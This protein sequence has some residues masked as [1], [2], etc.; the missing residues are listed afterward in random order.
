MSKKILIVGIIITLLLSNAIGLGFYLDQEKENTQ[1]KS[2]VDGYRLEVKR[3]DNYNKDLVEII[4]NSNE[5]I[6]NLETNIK[7]KKHKILELE[8]KLNGLGLTKWRD[9]QRRAKTKP[10]SAQSKN[11]QR[12]EVTDE[13][14]D[15][16]CRLVEAESGTEPYN[17]RVAV[18]QVVL[19]RVADSRFPNNIKDVIYQP[20][21]F[22]VVRKGRLDITPKESTVEA[23]HEAL[24]G[25]NVIGNCI[26]FW[27]TYVDK[28]CSLWELPIKYTIGSHVFTDG[29]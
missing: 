23:V 15:L 17:G 12:K 10:S 18:A 2:T 7:E 3:L 28:S 16:L 11:R 20:Y 21:Q 27:A 19:N 5:Q 4:N 6:E 9:Q 22:Q 29:Y 14:L 24:N 8:N 26:G 25:K 13:E 1:L